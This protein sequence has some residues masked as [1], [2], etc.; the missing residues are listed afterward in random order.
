MKKTLARKVEWDRAN[1]KRVNRLYENLKKNWQDAEH[2]WL[3]LEF[4]SIKNIRKFSCAVVIIFLYDS[5][6]FKRCDCTFYWQFNDSLMVSFSS[7]SFIYYKYSLQTLE[8]HQTEGFFKYI[9]LNCKSYEVEWTDIMVIIF[10]YIYPSYNDNRKF[11]VSHWNSLLSILAHWIFL[12]RETFSILFFL[13]LWEFL[14][15]FYIFIYYLRASP[16]SLTYMYII[17]FRERVKEEKFLKFLKQT[18]TNW[19]FKTQTQCRCCLIVQDKFS[20]K[21]STDYSNDLNF[22]QILIVTLTIVWCVIEDEDE[23]M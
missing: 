18:E 1:W 3:F 8:D 6:S 12:T 4:S 7:S 21:N 9:I 16:G 5:S 17:R 14:K 23:C 13:I 10:V 19:E 20:L 11:I 2:W 15:G 22:H